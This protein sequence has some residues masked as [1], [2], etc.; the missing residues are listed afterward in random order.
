MHIRVIAVA[1]AAAAA[2]SLLV[3][4]DV[5]AEQQSATPPVKSASTSSR[6]QLDD[7]EQRSTVETRHSAAS[8]SASDAQQ[9]TSELVFLD[10]GRRTPVANVMWIAFADG[11]TNRVELVSDDRGR[12]RLPVGAW[13][14][15]AVDTTYEVANRTWRIESDNTT[16]VLVHRVAALQLLVRDSAGAAI[17]GASCSLTL[18]DSS[19][20]LRPIESVTTDSNG[21]AAL[22]ARPFSPCVV[23]VL[24]PSFERALVELSTPPDDTLELR[25]ARCVSNATLLRALEAGNDAPVFDVSVMSDLD[26]ALVAQ[27]AGQS[28][29]LVVPAWVRRDEPLRATATGHLPLQFRLANL[30]GDELRLQR[31]LEIELTVLDERAPSATHAHVVLARDDHSRE[32]RQVRVQVGRATTIAL[33]CAPPLRIEAQL[34]DGRSAGAQL[35]DLDSDRTLELRIPSTPPAVELVLV[36]GGRN[37]TA[38]AIGEVFDQSGARLQLRPDSNG[39]MWLPARASSFELHAPGYAPVRGTPFGSREERQSAQRLVVEL[40]P[41]SS[42]ALLLRTPAGDPLRGVNVGVLVQPAPQQSAPSGG[43]IVGP[44]RSSRGVSD[45]DGRV[46]L[47]GLPAGRAS[48]RVWMDARSSSSREVG[49]LYA[50]ATIESVELGPAPLELVFEAPRALRIEVLDAA[51][52]GHVE[53]FSARDPRT[54]VTIEVNGGVWSGWIGD[55]AT[56]LVVGSTRLGYR[57][58]PLSVDSSSVRIEL[59]A[60]EAGVLEVLRGGELASLREV[61]ILVWSRGPGGDSQIG[62]ARAE[63]DAAGRAEAALYAPDGA[64]ISLEGA[65]ADGRRVSFEPRLVAW[66]TASVMQFRARIE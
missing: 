28:N 53:G 19:S 33:P 59:G 40:A 65:A 55:Q 36:D 31:A 1:L 12:A 57:N 54:D 29:E 60:R 61:E 63:L 27:S 58:V 24:A 10:A 17:E 14:I 42:R 38:Q 44:Q 21:R 6:E 37:L 35:D 46:E 48:V 66:S 23:A 7:S 11:S 22:I 16:V 64:L 5:G 47:L 50:P 2:L 56:Q 13:R 8:P 49:T 39:R 20:G 45:G 51:R 3:L 52:G 43:W 18:L 25:L 30:A 26:G 15:S 4:F 62:R 34:E 32:P 9:A 41:L